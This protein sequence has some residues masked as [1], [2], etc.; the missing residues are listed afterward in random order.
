[1]GRLFKKPPHASEHR[2]FVNDRY[3]YKHDERGS[4]FEWFV[5]DEVRFKFMHNWIT[6]DRIWWRGDY[7]EHPKPLPRVEVRK[8]VERHLEGDVMVSEEVEHDKY[9]P[10][11]KEDPWKYSH[12]N[13]YSIN[14][15]FETEED[16][17]HFLIRWA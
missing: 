5:G 16:L 11:E 13:R 8:W 2:D 7:T 12:A 10:D 6:D 3:P 4:E 1:M 9:Y 17:S 14:F 15:Y